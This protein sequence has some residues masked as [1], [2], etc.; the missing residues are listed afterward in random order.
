MAQRRSHGRRD[1]SGH[2]ESNRGRQH[3]R[4]RWQEESLYPSYGNSYSRGYEERSY[5]DYY[6]YGHGYGYSEADSYAGHS[7]YDAHTSRSEDRR[8]QHAS[9]SSHSQAYG[10][11]YHE[12]SS[13]LRDYR[14]DYHGSSHWASHGHNESAMAYPQPDPYMSPVHQD[15]RYQY[16][17]SHR[18][19]R[20]PHQSHPQN[21]RMPDPGSPLL[22]PAPLPPA[23][24]R[25]PS[26]DYLKLSEEEPAHLGSNQ[27]DRKLLILDLNGT[28]VFRTAYRPK[29]RH[30]SQ[31]QTEEGDSKDDPASATKVSKLRTAH[32]RPYLP[33]FRN[34]L[35]TPET[36]AWLDVMVWS[37]AQPHS[38]QG[39][40]E[41]VFGPDVYD[42]SVGKEIVPSGSASTMDPTTAEGEM[43]ATV[44]TKVEVKEVDA[45]NQKIPAKPRLLAIWAR[46]TLGLS[47]SH[48]CTSRLLRTQV[49]YIYLRLHTPMQHSW[50]L[51]VGVCLRLVV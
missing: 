32:P 45:A 4:E 16:Q 25:A 5:Y 30:Q 38:V 33:S 20:H 43:T 22:N 28:L 8:Y 18:Q 6:D 48:Y 46:D 7:Y 26:P 21:S 11:Y 14:D 3:E 23:P 51:F 49:C 15:S 1:P 19:S 40:V 44:E 29:H 41:R 10:E 12:A 17:P 39:M 9:S 2:Y 27:K 36:Q 31:P 24:P 47:D 13:Y 35:F 42:A 50:I 37:S 34:Y